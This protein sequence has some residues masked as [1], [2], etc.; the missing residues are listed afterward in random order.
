MPEQTSGA[1][2]TATKPAVTEPVTGRVEREFTVRDRGQLRQALTRFLRHRLAVVSL[3]VFILLV[4]LAFIAPLFWKYKYTQITA[5][6]SVPPS[7]AHPFGT[8]NLGHDM[9]AV[10]LRGL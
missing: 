8:D 6:N 10:T 1:P 7:L 5:D 3:S 9:F 4:L 2:A